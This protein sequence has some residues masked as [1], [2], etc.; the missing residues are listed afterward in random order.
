MPRTISSKQ[1]GLLQVLSIVWIGGFT[2]VTLTLFV[3]GQDFKNHA[4][5]PIPPALKFVFLAAT[6]AGTLLV[7][8]Y[9]IRLKRVAIDGD[10]LR[11]SSWRRTVVV[12][13]KEIETLRENRWLS[14][15]PV[16][17]YFRENTAFGRRI[18]FMPPLRMTGVFAP[19]SPLVAKL[20]RATAGERLDPSNSDDSMAK[21]AGESK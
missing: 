2:A 5:K 4:G 13:L 21:S 16:T 17:I 7:Y 9:G 6:I 1:T 10:S 3:V 19:E 8:L 20:R 12:G 11:I 14:T 18:V 15:R